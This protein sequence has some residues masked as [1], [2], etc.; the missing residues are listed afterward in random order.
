[1]DLEVE[2][3]VDSVSELDNEGPAIGKEKKGNLR[4]GAIVSYKV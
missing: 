3:R 4:F 2:G 1:M